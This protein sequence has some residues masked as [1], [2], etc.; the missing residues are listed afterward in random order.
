MYLSD[1]DAVLDSSNWTPPECPS[2]PSQDMSKHG[3]HLMPNHIAHCIENMRQS[4]MCTADI[5]TVV[6]Q[7][8][9]SSQTTKGYLNVPHTCRNFDRLQDWAKE[10]EMRMPF[11]HYVKMPVQYEVPTFP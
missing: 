11:D 6:W 9:D 2:A 1:W 4:F 7:W 5:S 3:L 8:E 10:N